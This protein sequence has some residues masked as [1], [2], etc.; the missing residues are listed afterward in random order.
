MATDYYQPFH[1]G[2]LKKGKLGPSVIEIP[3][4]IK[5]TQSPPALITAKT[6]IEEE[7]STY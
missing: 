5:K 7:R 3:E 4:W 2:I 1:P 6:G